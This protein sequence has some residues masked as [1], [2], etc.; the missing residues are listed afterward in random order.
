[1]DQTSKLNLP[2]IMPNQASKHVT[3][4]EGLKRL[5]II[6]QLS[7]VSAVL[8]VE[9][10]TPASGTSFIL[11]EAASGAYWTGHP[12]GTIAT[13]DDSTWSFTTPQDAVSYT[14]LTLPTTPYV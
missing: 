10:D 11:P 12:A 6:V 14:H 9:P 1:M 13:F 3:L 2:F 5:D 7:V 4:N 8:S